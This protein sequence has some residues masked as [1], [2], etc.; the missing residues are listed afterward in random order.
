M[1]CIVHLRKQILPV[2]IQCE[3]GSLKMVTKHKSDTSK[4]KVALGMGEH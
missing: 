4:K 3:E 1:V 2:T